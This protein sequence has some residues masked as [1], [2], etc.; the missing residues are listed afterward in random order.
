MGRLTARLHGQFTGPESK[1]AYSTSRLFR[2]SNRSLAV[3]YSHMGV[4]NGEQRDRGMPNGMPR[5]KNSRA[6]RDYGV[7]D[8]EI[9]CP[10]YWPRKEK[11][12]LNE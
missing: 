7:V 8:R 12:L 11:S 6:L 1:K 3:C 9:A 4:M 10:V 2:S 5:V